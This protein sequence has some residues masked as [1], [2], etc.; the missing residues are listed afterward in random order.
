MGFYLLYENF[1]LKLEVEGGLEAG[2]ADGGGR[3]N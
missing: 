2:V 3:L 1:K